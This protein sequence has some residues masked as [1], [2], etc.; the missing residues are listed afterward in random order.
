MRQPTRGAVLKKSASTVDCVVPAT[1]V[2]GLPTEKGVDMN[3]SFT[4]REE[5]ERRPKLAWGRK[6]CL[7][8]TNCGAHALL[9]RYSES[10]LMPNTQFVV[11][12][13]GIKDDNLAAP[14]TQNAR[15]N[16]TN[17]IGSRRPE[18]IACVAVSGKFVALIQWSGGVK[19]DLDG[20]RDQKLGIRSGNKQC[21]NMPQASCLR[22][23]HLLCTGQGSGILH[24]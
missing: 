17:P 14:S 19:I 15:D 8:S 23:H 11:L 5:L 13:L 7:V 4:E 22:T 2:G 20:P 12:G 10:Y 21:R 9:H 6:I 18:L 1:T 3:E 24:P 16:Q